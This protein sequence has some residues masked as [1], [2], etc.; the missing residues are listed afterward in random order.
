MLESID[1]DR[2]SKHKVSMEDIWISQGREN[3][4]DFV[5]NWGMKLKGSDRD[6][7]RERK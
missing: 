6:E 2:L 1:T 3:E 5:V 4:I 7:D